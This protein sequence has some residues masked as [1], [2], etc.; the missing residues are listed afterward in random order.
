MVRLTADDDAYVR[1]I[2]FAH[3][4]VRVVQLLVFGKRYLFLVTC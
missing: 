4:R 2:Q 3:K 1:H